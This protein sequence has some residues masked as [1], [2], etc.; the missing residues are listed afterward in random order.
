MARSRDIELADDIDNA[1]KALAV[2]DTLIGTALRLLTEQ[3]LKNS[4]ALKTL[5]RVLDQVS[6]AKVSKGSDEAWLNFY[7]DFLAVYDSALRRKTGSYYT[8]PEV[9]QAMVRLTDEALRAPGRYNLARGLAAT[10]V[11]IADPAVGSGTFP[12][13]ILRKIAATI[14]HFD[15]EGAVGGALTAA[16]KRLY[17]FELQFGPYAVA[18]LRLNAEMLALGAQGTPQLFVTD[19]L[20]DPFADKETGQGIYKEISKSRLEAA[21]IKR[22]APITVVIGNPPLQRQGQWE[23]GMGREWKRKRCGQTR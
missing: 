13:A 22:E 17:G 2:T 10:S 4:P 15:T 12:L 20:A 14:E 9:V 8:P 21:K 6:W 7:E 11:H 23:G 19:T 3:T 18:Q 16:A 5:A 1:A